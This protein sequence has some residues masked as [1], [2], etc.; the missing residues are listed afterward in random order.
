MHKRFLMGFLREPE[1]DFGGGGGGAAASVEDPNQPQ[2]GQGEGEGAQGGG[3]VDPLLQAQQQQQQQQPQL[4]AEQWAM[5]QQQAAPQQ[6]QQQPQM[7]QEQVDEMLKVYHP[8]EALVEA[9]FGDA[10]T[11]ETRLNAFQEMVRGIVGHVTT[12]M[13]HSNTLMRDELSQQFSPALEM[14]EEQKMSDFSSALQAAY[15]ALKGQDAVIR[16]VTANLKAQ[17]YA[18]TDPLEAGRTVAGQVEQFIRTVN[19]QFSLAN[20][21]QSQQGQQTNMPTMAGG[22]SAGGGGGAAGAANA[23]AGGQKKQGWQSVFD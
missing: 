13:G 11:P 3:Y 6:Q 20:G 19:P 7:T 12:V 18:P 1:D 2:G 22:M 16:Q 17:G 4:T 15:P 14:V 8:N 10:A 9:L 21:A 5:L 23:G